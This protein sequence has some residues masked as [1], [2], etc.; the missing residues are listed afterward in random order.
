MGRDGHLIDWKQMESDYISGCMGYR[1][2]AQKYGV[3]LAQV[4]K[5]G[6]AGDW[7][8]RREA[9]RRGADQEAEPEAA[10]ADGYDSDVC[11]LAALL[12]DKVRLSILA[13]EVG[14]TARLK[15]LAG[16]LRDLR[17]VSVEDVELDRA[18][19]QVRIQ[20]M[21]QRLA[22]ENDGSVLMVKLADDLEGFAV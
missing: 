3:P 13:A 21:E 14:D 10:Q 15:Q 6:K 18:M 17:A 9:Y 1:Q 20:V 12:L 22:A 4:G 19:R 11:A 16:A 8:V 5:A 7:P 2:L